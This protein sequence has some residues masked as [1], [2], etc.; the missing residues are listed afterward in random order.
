M[1]RN[2]PLGGEDGLGGDNE[3]EANDSNDSELFDTTVTSVGFGQ[4]GV[5]LT[6]SQFRFLADCRQLRAEDLDV[7]SNIPAITTSR[8]TRHLVAFVD[9]DPDS[10]DD[11]NDQLPFEV[12]QVASNRTIVF[13]QEGGGK[14]PAVMLGMIDDPE[15][16]AGLLNDNLTT[17][18]GRTPDVMFVNVGVTGANGAAGLLSLPELL[19]RNLLF[20][21][22]QPEVYATAILPLGY[23]EDIDVLSLRA[24]AAEEESWRSVVQADYLEQDIEGAYGN[25][26]YVLEKAQEA[27]A[28]GHYQALLPF[29]NSHLLGMKAVNTSGV[30]VRD[31]QD[32][33]G[34]QR[35]NPVFDA[36]QTLYQELGVPEG[37]APGICNRM[38]QTAKIPLLSSRGYIPGVTLQR[39]MENHWDGAE[40]R[41]AFEGE[42]IAPGF[43]SVSDVADLATYYPHSDIPGEVDENS[44]D[45]PLASVAKLASLLLSAPHTSESVRKVEF[46]LHA[47]DYTLNGANWGNLR[48]SLARSLPGDPRNLQVRFHT[49]DGLESAFPVGQDEFAA[50]A[51]ACLDDCVGPYRQRLQDLRSGHRRHSLQGGL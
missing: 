32:L 23:D 5:N 24:G 38:A 30:S 21:G 20:D 42:V 33:V 49:I 45:T 46:I 12:D 36:Y 8:D 17:E 37:S 13:D 3:P 34:R 1:Q 22:Q 44:L 48:D 6:A 25:V 43:F 19:D 16:F 2:K 28:D 41:A 40:Y 27:V 15:A 31:V 14:N 11:V 50:W 35:N 9:S 51:Y 29:A 47:R 39:D 4:G 7:G 18:Q 10:I 26:P